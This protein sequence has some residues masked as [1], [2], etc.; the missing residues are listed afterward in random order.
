L[1]PALVSKHKHVF[2]LA[3]STLVAYIIIA[4]LASAVGAIVA[5]RMLHF[6]SIASKGSESEPRVSVVCFRIG[7]PVSLG[8]AAC[9]QISGAPNTT[10]DPS[11]VYLCV[12]YASANVSINIVTAGG[13]YPARAGGVCAVA[14]QGKPLFAVLHTASGSRV[15]EVKLR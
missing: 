12:V 5:G 10:I 3:L 2:S 4:A 7:K 8:S 15:V 1:P 14:V 9:P 11:G 13:E 6:F